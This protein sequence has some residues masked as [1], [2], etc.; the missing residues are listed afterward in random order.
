MPLAGQT[1]NEFAAIV[2]R[3]HPRRMI[4]VAL[5]ILLHLPIDAGV[6]ISLE[7][8]LQDALQVLQ[9]LRF[10]I[11]LLPR[12]ILRRR[13]GIWIILP[14]FEYGPGPAWRRRI[15]SIGK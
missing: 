12:I 8:I 9:R 10:E 4:P 11:K 1:V 2:G 5:L 6:G 3:V 15:M 7:T 13:R 14:Q